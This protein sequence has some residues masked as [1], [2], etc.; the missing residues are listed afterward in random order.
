MIIPHAWTSDVLTAASLHLNAYQ[1]HPL[2]QEFCTND[3]PLS[4]DLVLEPLRLDADGYV[5]VPSGPGLGVA[6]DEAA[7]RKYSV[8]ALAVTV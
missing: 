5:A 1:K 4:R 2:F 3:T 6:L 8:D 7:V